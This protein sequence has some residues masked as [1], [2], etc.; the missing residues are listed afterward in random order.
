MT[1]DWLKPITHREHCEED[2]ISPAPL[3]STPAFYSAS[4]EELGD[5]IQPICSGDTETI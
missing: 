4:S 3:P 1:L 2:Y 5:L